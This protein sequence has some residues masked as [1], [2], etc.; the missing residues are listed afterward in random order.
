MCKSTNLITTVIN[1]LALKILDS[2]EFVEERVSLGCVGN[3]LIL[4][5]ILGG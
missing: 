4:V 3:I 2:V 1:T 5:S